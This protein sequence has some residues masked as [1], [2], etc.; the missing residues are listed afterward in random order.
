MRG[1]NELDK[2]KVKSLYLDGFSVNEI[3]IRM[4]SNR[5]AVKKCIQR[6]FSDLRE[7]NKAKRE[8]KKLQ[9]A[10][11]KKLTY[12]ECRKYM[13]DRSF[14]K[15]NSSIYK[16]NGHGNFSVKNEKELGC[17][18]PFDVPRNF[19]FKKKF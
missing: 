7:H 17:V 4:D 12:R 10:E 18:V 11:V 3:A 8:L 5:E 14:I 1:K 13:S 16:H 6:N 19:N 15:T 2:S 9:D